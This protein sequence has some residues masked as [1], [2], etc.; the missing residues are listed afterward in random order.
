MCGLAIALR[1]PPLVLANAEPT[2]TID[3][4][5]GVATMAA[6]RASGR[7]RDPEPLGQP[8]VAYGDAELFGSFGYGARVLCNIHAPIRLC[9]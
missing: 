2:Q 8:H 9:C 5:P 1:E 7:G 6:R 3:V 4:R